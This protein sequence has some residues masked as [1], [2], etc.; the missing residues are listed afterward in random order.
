MT[1]TDREERI[2]CPHCGASTLRRLSFCTICRA[3]LR[4]GEAEEGGPGSPTEAEESW[5]G[6]AAAAP[7][8]HARPSYTLASLALLT[9]L[10]GIFLGVTVHSVEY[11]IVFVFLCLP[12]LVRTIWINRRRKAKGQGLIFSEK[13]LTFGA[14]LGVVVVVA[15]VSGGTAAG[16]IAVAV[17]GADRGG[18]GAVFA[19][20]IFAVVAGG[21]VGLLLLRWLWRPRE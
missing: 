6:P 1:A 5:P 14:S 12:A 19:M 8:V 9:A 11:G 17:Q 16:I 20:M 4:E 18:D 2:T 15:G 7:Q 21:V 3:R 10:I 13:I